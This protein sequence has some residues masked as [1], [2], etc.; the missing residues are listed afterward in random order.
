MFIRYH[1]SMRTNE[2]TINKL[3]TIILIRLYLS[4]NEINTGVDKKSTNNEKQN[5]I[6]VRTERQFERKVRTLLEL[7][8]TLINGAIQYAIN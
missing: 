3:Q 6:H 5:N 1:A 4:F 2:H 8:I 7:K